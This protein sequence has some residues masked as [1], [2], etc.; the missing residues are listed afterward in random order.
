MPTSIGGKIKNTYKKPRNNSSYYK[1]ATLKSGGFY[2]IYKKERHG[3]LVSLGN[4]DQVIRI[5]GSDRSQGTCRDCLMITDKIGDIE[6][7]AQFLRNR[8]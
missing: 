7:V 1:T 2:S 5:A 8:N 4:A 3:P 6:S